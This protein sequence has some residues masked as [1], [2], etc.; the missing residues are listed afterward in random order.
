MNSVN[1]LEWLGKQFNFGLETNK[2]FN[3]LGFAANIFLS[4]RHKQNVNHCNEAREYGVEFC[5]KIAPQIFFDCI[6]KTVFR[7][8]LIMSYKKL[9]I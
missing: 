7:V 1:F 3:L 6:C 4:Y 2:F 5:F 9:K 8:L